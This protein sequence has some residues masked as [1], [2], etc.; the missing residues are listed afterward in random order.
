MALLSGP[1]YFQVLIAR[2]PLTREY[3]DRVIEAVF[4]GMGPKAPTTAGG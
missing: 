3:V 4:A 1:F 2:Q